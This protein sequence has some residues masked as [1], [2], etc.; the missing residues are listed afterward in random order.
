M[1]IHEI[2]FLND[3]P[4]ER[5]RSD[6]QLVPSIGR[7]WWG[8]L[9][10][11]SVQ[12]PEV[13][14]TKPRRVKAFP[15]FVASSLNGAEGGELSRSRAALW[16]RVRRPGRLSLSQPSIRWVSIGWLHFGSYRGVSDE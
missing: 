5:N 3:D 10:F 8:W 2:I 13:L 7:R 1:R 4:A 16:S 9:P 14:G 11:R 6:P 15:R 12:V